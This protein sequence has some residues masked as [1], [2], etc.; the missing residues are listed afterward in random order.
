[1]R[2][3]LQRVVDRLP[4]TGYNVTKAA[5]LEGYSESYSNTLIHR[6]IRRYIGVKNEEEIRDEFLK[7]LDRDIK[8]FKREK[9]NTNYLRCKELK[10]KI[11]GLQLDRKEVT[12]KTTPD[13]SILEDYFAKH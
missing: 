6:T 5:K 1:M 8:R 9:D 10:G 7:G 3:K 13:S 11:L 12:N 4:E 2:A